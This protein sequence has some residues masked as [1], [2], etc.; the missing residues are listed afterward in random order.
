MAFDLTGV[1]IFFEDFDPAQTSLF[2][3]ELDKAASAYALER[4]VIHGLC[5]LSAT[6]TDFSISSDNLRE[7]VVSEST[8]SIN[9]HRQVVCALSLAVFSCPHAS[10]AE[11]CEH[12]NRNALR[13]YIAEANS[14]LFLFL[15]QY[16][17]SDLLT[18][19]EY[20]GDEYRSGEVVADGITHQDLQQTSFDDES[21]DIVITCEV[22]EHIPDALRAEREVVRILKPG[23]VYCFT[24]PFIPHGERDLVLAERGPDGEIR[25]FAEPQ[26]HGDPIRPEE[27]ILVYRV[28][29]FDDLKRRF[30]SL[31]C[32]FRTYR[33][34]SKAL[35]ILGDNGWVHI[36][37]KNLKGGSRAGASRVE[38][39]GL[40]GL[41]E[42]V[43][44]A[45]ARLAESEQCVRQLEDAL[46]DAQAEL[47][48]EQV[49]L[50]GARR[51]LSK[52]DEVLS[53]MQTSRSWRLASS[54]RR[55]QKLAG[56]WRPLSQQLRRRLGLSVTDDFRGAL[57]SPAE[58]ARVSKELKVEG[59]VFSVGAPVARVE[60]FL[61]G[62]YFGT[63]SYGIER[64]DVAAAR[65]PQTPTACGFADL[66]PL[67]GAPP[68]RE[69]LTVRVFDE[70]GHEQLYER[71]VFVE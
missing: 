27:G 70:N 59:W 60:A 66:L 39:L 19:S 4:G 31:G 18:Y 16:L 7:D 32:R 49:A 30:E 34:W 40:E 42:E 43:A 54:L 2:D 8:R 23:G 10:L 1:P 53:W 45:R 38:A 58:G 25:H 29:A 17:N 28:F 57:E 61:G 68:G 24:V 21:F 14:A 71:T 41:R 13:V 44:E 63:V 62:D 9:R 11:F 35:G 33:F 51:Q 64:P 67:G 55:A 12:V 20:F 46:S 6:E 56:R 37:R 36:V 22:F 65:G 52:R 48:R 50:L 5:N 69:T 3:P 26:Y 15:K 47:A